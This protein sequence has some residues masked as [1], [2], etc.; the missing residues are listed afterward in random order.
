MDA[1]AS[2]FSTLEYHVL[3]ALAG[4]P[5]H[6]YAVKDAVA[7]ESSGTLTPRAGSLYRVIA[8]LMT[9]GL[10]AETDATDSAPHP[11]HPRKYYGL[12]ARGRGALAAETSRLKR[13]AAM[14]EKRLRIAQGGS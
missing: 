1:K 10:V 6:G 13:A 5:L 4:G 7:D 2:G 14:A 11:G 12:T 8:R 9:S 3:L